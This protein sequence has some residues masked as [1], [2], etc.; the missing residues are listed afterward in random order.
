M[1]RHGEL[2]EKEF[3][4]ALLDFTNS[5]NDNSRKSD[6]INAFYML[7]RSCDGKLSYV[8]IEMAITEFEVRRLF[9]WVG[10]A[11]RKALVVMTT[12]MRTHARFCPCDALIA[13][14]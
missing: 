3:V 6:F 14:A 4:D 13:S 12:L 7:D 11:R 10:A 1:S 5:R 8:E 2:T 9:V